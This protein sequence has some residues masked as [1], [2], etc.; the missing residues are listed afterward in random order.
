M[1]NEHFIET[2][3]DVAPDQMD[4]SACNAEEWLEQTLEN[5]DLSPWRSFVETNYDMSDFDSFDDLRDAYEAL[6]DS[7]REEAWELPEVETAVENEVDGV[8]IWLTNYMDTEDKVE[9]IKKLTA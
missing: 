4:S 3:I 2:L 5:E 9:A 6:A 7:W 1:N 8:W